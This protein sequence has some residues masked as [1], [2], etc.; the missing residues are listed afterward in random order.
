MKTMSTPTV[1]ARTALLLAA[2]AAPLQAQRVERFALDG[3]APA[4]H[5]L[6]GEVSVV[7]G[8]GSQ[9]VV[10][11]TRGGADAGDLRVERGGDV[12]RVVYPGDR[13]VYARMGARSRSTLQVRRDGSLNLRGAGRRSDVRRVTVA[14]SGGGTRAHADVRVLVPAGRSVAVYQGVGRVQVTNV[15]GRI[16]VDASSASVQAQGT[17]GSLDVDVGSGSVEVRDVRGDLSVD[18][19]SGSVTADNV[20]DTN[21][22]LDT[23]SGTV[24]GRNLRVQSLKVDTGS[25]RVALSGVRARS[26]EVDTGSG[27]VELGLLADVDNLVVDTG[28]GGVTVTVP[29]DFG[30]RLDI[31]TGS[32]GIHVD[33]PV[34]G[35]N[36]DSRSHL[37]GRVGDGDGTVRIDTGSGGV[38]IRRG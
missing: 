25:G 37:T 28:S 10:E 19:G 9:V 30:A 6:A 35:R 5:N 13:V 23:G 4:V 38:R 27:G 20:Q 36:R 32:G 3:R 18:T 11:I 29:S 17:R 31:D 1:L 8:S 7:A 2:A 33:L 14:G 22:E 26:V 21:L 12:V 34:T 24:T 16:A 15:D